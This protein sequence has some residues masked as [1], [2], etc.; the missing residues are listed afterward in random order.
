MSILYQH[1]ELLEK[2]ETFIPYMIFTLKG[3]IF[4]TSNLSQAHAKTSTVALSLHNFVK[5]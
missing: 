5:A 3:V 1:C 2:L 4:I